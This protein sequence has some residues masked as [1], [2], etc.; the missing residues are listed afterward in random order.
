[1]IPQTIEIILFLALLMLP[2]G[3]ALYWYHHNDQ[4][5]LPVRQNRTRD[6]RYFSNSFRTL[7]QKAWSERTE[8]GLTISKQ[9]E[10]YIL[11]DQMDPNGYPEVCEN[12]V[13]AEKVDF[14]AP[15]KTSFQKEIFCWQ[16]AQIGEYVTL[17]AIHAEK[18]LTI[19]NGSHILRW[20]DANELV[21]VGDDCELGISLTSAERIRTGK[22]CRFRRL[23]APTI[24]IGVN[25]D[26][27]FEPERSL[28]PELYQVKI[29][30]ER[31][32]KRRITASDAGENSGIIPYSYISGHKIVADEDIVL[33]G[34]I[35][36]HKGILLGDRAV[37][38]GNIFCDGD[39]HIGRS[40]VVLGDIF[41][42]GNIY[43]ESGAVAG[44]EG[45]V[46]SIIARGTI[47]VEENCHIHGYIS[48]EA[49][50][51]C[52]PVA[53][54]RG[55][56]EA[57][58]AATAAEKK[59]HR[60]PRRWHS[61]AAGAAMLAALVVLCAGAGAF[62]QGNNAARK[63]GFEKEADAYRNQGLE[64]GMTLADQPIEIA[65][66]RVTFA[67]RVV[68]RCDFTDEDVELRKDSLHR[69]VE[70][71]SHCGVNLYTMVVPL[72]I[73]FEGG[74]S[75]D[76]GY[77]AIVEDET[78]R[79][80]GLENQLLDTVSDYAVTLP[81][82]DVLHDHQEEYLFY[83]Q[84]NEWT[85]RG[86]YYA[87]Q[88]FLKA[89][90]HPGFPI[91]DFY[92]IAKAK[93]RGILAQDGMIEDRQYYYLYKD[94]NPLVTDIITGEKIPMV[95]LTRASGGVFL[96]S[97]VSACKIDGLADNGEVLMVFGNQDAAVL[98]PWFVKD[99]QTILYVNIGQFSTV[100][101]D[102]WALLDEYAVTDLLFVEEAGL[103]VS[104]NTAQ[105]QNLT[106]GPA[107]R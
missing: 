88:E 49:G 38:C 53:E 34:S 71:E 83:R 24:E 73:G 8:E 90:G 66:D 22:N 74:F 46:H 76:T 32:H 94:Y 45:K 39:I 77:L 3:F 61:A 106:A 18:A 93:T 55:A 57:E 92:E 64:P 60:E 37:V 51:V 44:R 103:M 81:L 75:T 5:V 11:A 12:I 50:G 29:P 80:Q 23:F 100:H 43:L 52:C 20:A 89:A 67:D 9:P 35:R 65:A 27:A 21:S 59:Q 95:S 97:S 28:A 16:N 48:T 68:M 19:A 105:Y 87:A 30:Q 47:T 17:R 70:K 31:K 101:N 42:Q 1:M 40:C 79:L 36:S 26:R 98:A 82:M 86:A 10:A 104:T 4:S 62:L 54:S 84:S 69:L 63:P 58:H 102:F 15:E 56:S 91:E 72:R 33:A 107:W 14:R 7:F 99:Y 2:I 96:G 41:A 13:V 6:P 78:Q 85:A 25:Q